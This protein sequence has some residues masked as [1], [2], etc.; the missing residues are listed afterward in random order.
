M[1]LWR[2]EALGG[3][4]LLEKGQHVL[5]HS[6]TSA[7]VISISP[8]TGWS[9]L[10]VGTTWISSGNSPKVAPSPKSWIGNAIR[11]LL[12]PSLLMAFIL[13]GWTCPKVGAQGWGGDMFPGG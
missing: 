8:Y 3:T 6:R 10:P 7:D 9:H 1:E 4:P 5:E 13:T 12:S 11:F 2:G